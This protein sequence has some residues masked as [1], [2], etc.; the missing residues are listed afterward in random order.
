MSF[1]EDFERDHG[2]G[3][4]SSIYS[5]EDLAEIIDEQQDRINNL[6]RQVALD[7]HQT[8]GVLEYILEHEIDDYIDW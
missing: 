8:T 2:E 5:L 1:I 6:N 7:R 3:E 4:L